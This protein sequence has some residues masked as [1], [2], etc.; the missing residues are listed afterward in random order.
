LEEA[1]D[2]ISKHGFPIIIKA[3]MGG[4]GRGMRVVHEAS[5]LKEAFSRATSEAL[6]AFGD[7]TVF[8]ERYL[9]KPRHIEVQILGD[10][11]GLPTSHVRSQLCFMALTMPFGCR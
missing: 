7:G 3:A 4:G 1:H 6:A 8:I 2:F 5:E 11:T 10:K 9:V